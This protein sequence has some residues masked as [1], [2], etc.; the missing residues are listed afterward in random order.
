MANIEKGYLYA[1]RLV[2]APGQTIPGGLENLKG[3]IKLGKAKDLTKREPGYQQWNRMYYPMVF[4]TVFAAVE[5][6]DNDLAEELLLEHFQKDNVVSEFGTA[7]R[8]LM[9]PEQAKVAEV[10]GNGRECFRISAEAAQ[11]ILL[12]LGEAVSL[13]S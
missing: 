3:L 8:Q 9:S 11:E 1:R 13:C 4:E 5:V 7:A 6:D 12:Q 10:V 2:L